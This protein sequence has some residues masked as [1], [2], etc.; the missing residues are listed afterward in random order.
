MASKLKKTDRILEAD[1]YDPVKTFLQSRGYEVKGEIGKVDVMA[2]RGAEPPIIVELK[3]AFSLTLFHQ[4]VDRLTLTD[5]VY[6][7]VPYKSGKAAAK[8]LKRNIS[9]CRSLGLGVITVRLRDGFVQIHRDPQ[10]YKPRKSSVKLARMMKEFSSREGDPNTGGVTRRTIVTAYRQDA[11]KCLT[12]LSGKDEMKAADVAKE[13]Y[14]PRARNIMSDNHYGWF[15][16]VRRG[17]YT[18]SKAGL[19][20]IAHLDKND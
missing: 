12:V 5:N 3:T 17:H 14:V 19:E 20:S 7:A 16:R 2:C 6:I 13:A 15:E 18:L 4:A 8:T 9:L 1:L 11:I 10:P